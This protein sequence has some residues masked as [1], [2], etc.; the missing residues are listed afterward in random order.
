MTKYI[1]NYAAFLKKHFDVKKPLTVVCDSSNGTTGI[2]LEKL[3]DIPN[4]TLKLI[5]TEANGDFPAHG[6]NPLEKGAT[7]QLA[8]TV[9]EMKAD[10]G[11]AFDADGDRAFFVDE[12][13]AVLESYKTSVILFKHSNPPYIGDELIYQ[14]LKHLKLYSDAELKATKIGSRFVKEAIKEFKASAGGEYSGHFYFEKFFGLDSGLFALVEVAN[15]VARM[16]KGLSSFFAELP[17]HAMAYASVKTEGKNVSELLAKIETAYKD[18]ATIG[19]LDGITL[20]FG[21]SWISIRASNTEPIIKFIAGAS[22]E[23]EAQ[24]LIDAIKAFI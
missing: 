3:L 17:P 21:P 23:T 4:L 6:P 1:E 5:N 8:K 20:D 14:A 13:G 11:V 2:V 24:K 16:D 10:F 7:D 15:T 22:S 9:V 19:H 12:K 18:K